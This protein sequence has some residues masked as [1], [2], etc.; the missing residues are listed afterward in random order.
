MLKVAA[1]FSN[2]MVLQRDKNV[3]VWGE[4]DCDKVSVSVNELGICVDAVCENG[5]WKATL[6]P[7]K[8]Q[9][10]V[11]VVV[12]AGN[13]QKTFT[14]VAVGEVWLCG[15]QS[16][17]EL[18]IRN[19]KDGKEL[20]SS[21]TPDCNVRFYY[22]QK[23]GMICDEFYKIEENTCWQ[24]ASEENSQAW[25]AVGLHFGMMLAKELGVT[26]GLIGCN[27]GGTSA[28]AWLDREAML[29]DKDTAVYVTEYEEKI[30]GKTL[31]ECIREYDEY[32]EY[33]RLWNEKSAK[34]YAEHEN[35]SWDEVQ[36]A[37]GKNLWPGPMGPKNPFRPCG[38]YET[39]LMRV[40][41]YT[42]RGFTYYQGE[43]DDH[44]PDTYYKLLRM[45]ITRWREE[46]G[47][48]ELSFLIV[49]LPMFKFEYDP[50][51]KHWVKIRE[52]QM[53]A[54]RTIKNTGI[55][56]ISDCGEFNNIH[57][58]DKK[59]VGERLALQALYSTYGRSDVSAFGPLFKD[60]LYKENE[61]ELCFDNAENGLVVKGELTGFEIAGQDKVFCTAQ[62]KVEGSRII[63]SCDKVT[64]PLYA[65]YDCFN[66]C[67]PCIFG[68]NGIPLAPFRTSVNDGGLV[69]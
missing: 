46:W 36:E 55:A 51:Y 38:L 17:M 57:P 22:T 39:M 6:P 20:L 15:G 24:T 32:C 64:K 63:L 21:L 30:A 42:L 28:S 47:D 49:Q 61:L 10:S 35:P 66:W 33:D 58:V 27:W 43:S 7:M 11:T 56:V 16:N 59:P 37:C 65:R 67:V 4:S 53:R 8:A 3:S 50:D 40:C 44:R 18:E 1:V 41:P 19:A 68:T 48:D 12:K 2:D 23:Q 60:V 62:A 14:N 29:S 52:A 26:V 31:E 9:N 45:L 69:L 5:S 25:S 54:F 34:Y 13:E